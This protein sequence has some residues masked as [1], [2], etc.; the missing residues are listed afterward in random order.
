MCPDGKSQTGSYS[1]R[2]PAP[3]LRFSVQF[4]GHR[5]FLALTTALGLSA[6]HGAAFARTVSKHTAN[7]QPA[8]AQHK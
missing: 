8:A 1:S 4:P 7:A 6:S 5:F 3:L 2:Q